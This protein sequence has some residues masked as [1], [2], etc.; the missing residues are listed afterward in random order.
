MARICVLGGTGFIGRHLLNRLVERGH[1]MIVPTRRRIRARELFLLPTADIQEADIYDRDT[2]A[3][4]VAE[5]DAVVN[6]V[7][8][9]HSRPGRAGGPGYGPDFERAHVRLPQMLAEA[10]AGTGVEQILHV[11]ALGA[12]SDAPS[13]YLRSKAAGEAAIRSG[14]VPVT[15]FRPSVVFGPE[16]Q[17]LNVFA[18]LQRWLPFMLLPCPE[19]RFQP[20]FVGDVAQCLV[21]G[22]LAN[23]SFHKTYE[24]CGPRV[25]T[26]RQLVQFAGAASGHPRPV[27]GLPAAA[28]HAQAWL[29]ERL[30]G[31]LMTRDNLRSMERA[32]VCDCEFPFGLAPAGLEAATWLTPAAQRAGDTHIG[33]SEL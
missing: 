17:F 22:L 32:N 27:F 11:S 1:R 30:P 6:L 25:C 26:L 31:K 28:A 15:V 5:C 12:A 10:A 4:L 29:M 18:H 9:L 33:S 24:L 16:D 13:E 8:V 19:A 21:R 2:L 3:R 14:T 23:G 20:V 7:G